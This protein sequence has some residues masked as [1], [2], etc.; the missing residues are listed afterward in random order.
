MAQTQTV[1][2]EGIAELVKLCCGE[3]ATCVKSVC[4]LTDSTPCA[5]AVGSTY[6]T[7][8]DAKITDSGLAIQNA[9]SVTSTET[10][11]ADDTIQVDHVFTA[12]GTKNVSG[13]IICNDDDDAAIMEVCF[14][15]V[16]AME[17]TDTLTFEGKIVLNQ[18]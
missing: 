6:A 1:T 12:S 14:N 9:D 5:A 15:A 13:V 4:C 16:L 3:A 18:A 10:N 7:P 11:E 17:D 2:D 8:A